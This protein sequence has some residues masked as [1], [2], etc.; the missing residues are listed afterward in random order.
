MERLNV[1]DTVAVNVIGP[2]LSDASVTVTV[3]AAAVPSVH[4]PTVATPFASVTCV[5]PL[6]VPELLPATNDT[7]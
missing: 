1:A 5:A 2:P 3:S 6:S 4:P 7:V